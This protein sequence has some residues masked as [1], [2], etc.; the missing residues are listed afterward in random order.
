MGI[1]FTSN[2]DL[3]T[4]LPLDSRFVVNS[5]SSVDSARSYEGMLVYSKEDQSIYYLKG[6][7]WTKVGAEVENEILDLGEYE[8]IDS[9]STDLLTIDPSYRLITFSVGEAT[10]LV[11]S[12]TDGTKTK[13]VMYYSSDV[14]TRTITNTG[15]SYS[16]TGW[17]S[18]TVKL[19][20]AISFNPFSTYSS[21]YDL[22]TILEWF[23][24]DTLE[25]LQ[26]RAENASIIALKYNKSRIP[27]TD[28]TITDT[29][30]QIIAVG[31]VTQYQIDMNLDGTIISG[32]SNIQVTKGTLIPNLETF[33]LKINGTD[34]SSYNGTS[35][36]IA[37]LV[38]TAENIPVSSSDPT[39]ISDLMAQIEGAAIIE[40]A[41]L[42]ETGSSN[43]LYILT[44][45]ETLWRWNGE[46]YVQ[47]T[48]GTSTV[49]SH[50]NDSEIHVTSAEKET[51]NNKLDS[52]MLDSKIDETDTLV[53]QC[54]L[55]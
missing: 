4:N 34:V 18:I 42:P 38:I 55:N 33:Y 29:T 3:Y 17:T 27:V 16:F 44:T 46:A 23:E 13:Q 12:Y 54:G 45:D 19:P 49:S 48:L 22:E 37:D 36:V 8:T 47:L 43:S 53:L 50:I 24:C 9:V 30:I 25:E 40:V 10:G 20:L 6:E 26:T 32:N 35:E 5:L 7:G 2:I 52:V 14:F 15:S 51:W 41:S 31:G 39:T 28:I 21:V 11:V 1:R